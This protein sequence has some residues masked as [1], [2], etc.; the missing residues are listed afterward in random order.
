[1]R[2]QSHTIAADIVVPKEG[3]DGVIVSAG[4][5][6]GGYALYVKGGRVHY[7]Y[8]FVGQEWTT[9]TSTENL[10]PGPAT[11]TLRFD[12]DGGGNG[13]GGNATLGVNGRTVAEK[14]I[15]RTAPTIFYWYETFDLGEDVGTSVGEYPSPFR[16]SGEIKKVTVEVLESAAKKSAPVDGKLKAKAGDK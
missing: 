2:N 13:K 1:M 9:L 8:N 7:T 6:M 3:G 16:F 12:C 15:P 10:P 5:R 11:V 4:G 14:R